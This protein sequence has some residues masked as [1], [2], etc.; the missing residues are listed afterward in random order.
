MTEKQLTFD[1]RNHQL[2]NINIWTA[3]SQW[4]VYDLR[5]SG[6]SFTSL[7]IERVNTRTA[8]TEVLYQ[9][10]QGAHVGVVT[11][12]PDLPPRYVCI[13][14]PENPDAYWQYD[15][16]HRRGV[17]VQHGVAENLD[18]CDITPPFTPGALRGGSH[19]HVFS[20]D[21][22]R[23]SFTYND[24]VMHEWDRAEDLR[25]VGVAVPLHAVCPHKQHPREYDG[26]HFCVLVSQT[27]A[28]PVPGSDEINRAY[29]EGWMGAEGY[30]KPDGSQQRWALAFIGDTL[31]SN[32]EKLSEVFIVDL[33]AKMQDFALAGD[34][35]LEGSATRLP[36]PPRGV[37]QRRLT[38]SGGR[39][40]PGVV[41]QPRHWL[42]ASPDGSAIAFLMKDDTGVVQLWTISPNGGAPQQITDS[43]S[44][45]QSAFSWHPDGQA[46]ALVCD[47]SVMLCEIASGRMQRVTARSDQAP[48][49]DAVV[50]SP[51]GQ[52][53]AFTRDINGYR[54]IFTAAL[55]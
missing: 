16:H 18:A 43:S 54:Q 48:G 12:S 53:V 29:E 22:S 42:R 11:A 50:I 41:S 49:G 36:A 34:L 19:V 27:T 51:D 31:D 55:S 9:A 1:D 25:N 2:T 14:G 39:R 28:T 44:D 21:G 7:T 24:H 20:P 52:Q 3:D 46:V 10:S 33:P 17:I 26:S 30:R 40:Y 45:I 8:A 4:L 47:N 6:A 35:P 13:H 32:G 15:F 5:P 37:I 38:F 23:L